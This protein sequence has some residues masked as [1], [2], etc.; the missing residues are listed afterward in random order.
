[1]ECIIFLVED[2]LFKVPRFPF[3]RSGIFATIFTLPSGENTI[4]EGCAD[5]HPFKLDGISK[6]DFQTFLRVVC[7]R[8]RTKYSMTVEKWV[9]V[10]KLST[11]WDFHETRELAIKE[12]SKEGMMDLVM[13]VGLAKQFKIPE[14]LFAG[15]EGLIKRKEA[16]SIAEAELLGLT[17]VVRLFRIREES[18]AR[19][20]T[21]PIQKR[22]PRWS[23][24]PASPGYPFFIP[25]TETE[26]FDR[27]DCRCTEE[28]RREFAEELR[29]VEEVA[30]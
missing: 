23:G 15:Y 11:M 2:T 27:T 4:V 22:G 19:R 17:T 30:E 1:M 8:D 10:L 18:V 20:H 3:E 6:I 24:G 5:E 28:I 26:E 12:L 9:S 29:E 7:P 14:W 25:E 13:K 16:I 21:I